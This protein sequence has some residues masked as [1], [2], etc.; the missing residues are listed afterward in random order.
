MLAVDGDEFDHRVDVADK[1]CRPQQHSVT[2]L[3]PEQAA[4]L[5]TD[6]QVRQHQRRPNVQ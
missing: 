6:L 1:D 5:V 3:Q 2:A 4:A